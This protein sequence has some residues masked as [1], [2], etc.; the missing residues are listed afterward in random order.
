MHSLRTIILVLVGALYIAIAFVAT[1]MDKPPLFT[2]IIGL[3]PLAVAGF[4]AAWNARSRIFFMLLYTGCLAVVV[5]YLQALRDHVP[6]LYFIQHAGAMTL[7]AITFGSTLNRNHAQALI[8]RIASFIFPDAID[9]K[10][11]RYTWKV[12]LAWTVFF[13]A[14]GLIS[15]LLFFF[16]RIEIW[17]AFANVFTPISL[18]AMF[19]GEYLIRLRTVPDGP[20]LNITA[21]IQAYRKYMQRQNTQ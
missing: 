14:T 3:L 15:V 13:V 9:D 8:S 16:A 7:L 21:T 6:W 20:R 11:L 17:S 10:Y 12:T 4:V 18:G 5:I 19:L 1:I 2:V